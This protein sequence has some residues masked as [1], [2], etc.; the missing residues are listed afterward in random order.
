M[1]DGMAQGLGNLLMAAV[2]GAASMGD[3]PA[4]P[5]RWS[6]IAEQDTATEACGAVLLEATDATGGKHVHYCDHDTSAHAVD[7]EHTCVCG[8]EWA[9]RTDGVAEVVGPGE[10]IVRPTEAQS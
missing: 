7:T 5:R 1:P 3:H 8:T 6:G 2:M 4:C 9:E 10:T